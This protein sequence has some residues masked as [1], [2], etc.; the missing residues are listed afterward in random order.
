MFMAISGPSYSTLTSSY[1]STSDT[2]SLRQK[3]KNQTLDTLENRDQNNKQT[4]FVLRGELLDD[5]KK[6]K[7][8]EDKK[9]QTIDPANEEAI[10]NYEI[11][12]QASND[13]LVTQKQGRIL[14]AYA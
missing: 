2:N 9:D 3:E 14:D 7:G 13:P 8:F 5:V 4:E 11:N 10:N 12:S 6:Y 1:L